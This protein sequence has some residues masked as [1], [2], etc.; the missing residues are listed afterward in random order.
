VHAQRAVSAICGDLAREVFAAHAALVEPQDR[1]RYLPALPEVADKNTKEF[2]TAFGMTKETP[3]RAT[4]AH[5]APSSLSSALNFSSGI[6]PPFVAVKKKEQEPGPPVQASYK[7]EPHA[8][9]TW[10][11]KSGIVILD[12][13]VDGRLH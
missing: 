7:G 9:S 8:I 1:K 4:P 2:L 13:T 12:A 5:G 11:C 3:P 6:V 10:G